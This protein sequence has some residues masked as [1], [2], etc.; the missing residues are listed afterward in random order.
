MPSEGAPSGGSIDERLR[1]RFGWTPYRVLGGLALFGCAA[2]LICDFIMWSMIEGY[3]PIS[4]TISELGA[5]PHHEI[6]DLGITLFAFGILSL[7]AGLILRSQNGKWAMLVRIAFIALALDVAAIALINE[8]GDGDTGGLVLHPYFVAILYGIVAFLLLF[9]PASTPDR[10]KTSARFSRAAGAL[11]IVAAP[12]FYVVPEDWN[13]LY[14]RVLG[15]VL[16][17][18]VAIAAYRLF[19][20]PDGDVRGGPIPSH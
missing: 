7:A 14:E 16:V 19:E 10:G 13:G 8:Y 18:S 9:G 15:V 17:S 2:V 20:K 3:S 5:G 11:W 6:Q 1:Q 12:F 4:Q